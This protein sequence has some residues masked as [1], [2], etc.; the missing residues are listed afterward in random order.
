MGQNCFLSTLLTWSL[1]RWLVAAAVGL[2]TFLVLGVPTAVIANPVFGRTIAP[3]LWA[4]NVLIAT[5]VLAG[6]L[7]ATYVRNDGPALI[8]SRS[9]PDVMPDQ[10]NARRGAFGGLLAYL[11]IGC[12]VCNKLVLIALGASGAVRIFA[13]VQPYLAGAGLFA[14]AWALVVRLRGELTCSLGTG[15][16]AGRSAASRHADPVTGTDAP[17][18]ADARAESR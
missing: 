17:E 15:T 4:M 9:V 10:R 18:A 11:A 3:T 5:S 1:R 14:L 2:G 8:R 6:L 13:P 12:P 7:S 16:G